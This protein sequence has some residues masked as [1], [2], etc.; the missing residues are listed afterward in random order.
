MSSL[1]IINSAIAPIALISGVGL[2]LLS[3]VNRLS[4]VIDRYRS[5][6]AELKE[7][8]PV[9]LKEIKTRELDIM[10]KRAKL[11]RY[12][13]LSIIASIVSTSTM[14]LLII[15]ARLSGYDI[16]VFINIMLIFTSFCIV[17]C[18]LF[19]LFEVRLTLH[20]VDMEYEDLKKNL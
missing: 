10:H 20:A 4:R 3:L 7:D 6:I 2:I 16:G 15:I 14:I 18:S 8:L 11:L 12:S 5:L 1:E 19:F 9:S 13:M 17:C